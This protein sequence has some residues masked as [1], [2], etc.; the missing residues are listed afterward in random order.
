MRLC[1]VLTLV[2]AIVGFT[3][4][5]FPPEDITVY[6]EPIILLCKVSIC[7]ALLTF[8]PKLISFVKREGLMDIL[9]TVLFP[10]TVVVCIF[11]LN[12][13]VDQKKL[14]YI[15]L[16]LMIVCGLVGGIFKRYFV[17]KWGVEINSYHPETD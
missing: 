6:I 12:P 11:I 15:I 16:F 5:F 3:A 10:F 17:K 13:D 2:M 1:E 4:I 9:T 14:E 8:V 7:V